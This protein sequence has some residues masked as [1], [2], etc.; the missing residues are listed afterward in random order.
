[1]PVLS[2]SPVIAVRDARS[3]DAD[4]I[5]GFNVALALES[6]H[7][8][9]DPLV[10]AR[11][12]QRVF[13]SPAICRYFVAE[14]AGEVVGQTLINYEV[15]DWRDGLVWWIHSVYV[16]ADWRGRGVFKVLFAHTERLARENGSV[17]NL[18]LFVETDNER[19]MR[20]YEALGMK[21]EKY[22]LYEK[23]I[24]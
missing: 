15:T 17:R 22:A 16:R 4:I 9:L 6:E 12:V 1:M 20:T 10:V 2:S 14:A 7:K 11:G 23:S 8:R 21:R 24:V 5:T 3:D 18:R 19:A 13:S